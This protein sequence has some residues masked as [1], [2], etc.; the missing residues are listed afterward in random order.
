MSPVAVYEKVHTRARRCFLWAGL[1][2]ALCYLSAV[3]H[4]LEGP[5][6][7]LVYYGNLNLL[8]YNVVSAG[9]ILLVVLCLRKRI[10][11]ATG[12]KLCV[13]AAQ[14]LSLRRRAAVYVMTVVP[15][16]LVA[17]FLGRQF[18]IVYMLG[19]RVSGMTAL[20]NGAGYVLAAAKLFA[21]TAV[22]FLVQ[23]GME[24]VLGKKTW[25]PFGGLAA[26]LT[27]GVLDWI[28][29]PSLL[30]PVYL[31]LYG[32]MGVLALVTRGRFFVTWILALVLYIF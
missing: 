7:S 17:I 8:F 21:A 32:Y 22:V 12:V 4:L 31:I 25:I 16:L 13:P 26:M 23:S 27:F 19:T 10:T 28:I 9:Y 3:F 24:E 15:I 18:K 1:L 29:A 6:F 14:P 5:L 20:G 2:V 30:S 11:A